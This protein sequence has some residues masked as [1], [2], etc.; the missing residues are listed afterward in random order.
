[1]AT[2]AKLQS[3]GE[4]LDEMDRPDK[5]REQNLRL[6][7]QLSKTDP[8]HTK[9]FQRAGGFRGTAVKPIWITQR[10]TEIFGPVGE[11]WGMDKP[12]YT[13]VHCQDGEVLVYCTVAG[14]YRE[15]GKEKC[16]VYGVG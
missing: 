7:S 8:A 10:L 13:T 9:G 12:D 5:Q 1:M 15:A 3:V 4:V 2:K 11:G 14:W 6:W 16:F